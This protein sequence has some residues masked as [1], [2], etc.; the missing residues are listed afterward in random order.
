MISGTTPAASQ[1]NIAPV[2]PNPVKISSKINN[3][4]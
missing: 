4:S 2:R 3:A 1:A